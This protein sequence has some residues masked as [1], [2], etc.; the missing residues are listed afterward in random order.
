MPTDVMERYDYS[1]FWRQLCVA[2]AFFAGAGVALWAV[3]TSQLPVDTKIGLALGVIGVP[4][5]VTSTW[6]YVVSF[7]LFLSS[8]NSSIDAIHGRSRFLA[9]VLEVLSSFALGVGLWR[10]FDSGMTDATKIGVAT[11]CIGVPLKLIGY[12]VNTKLLV[13]SSHCCYLQPVPGAQLGPN[14]GSYAILGTIIWKLSTSTLSVTTKLSIG[15]AILGARQ[16]LRDRLARRYYI[17]HYDH[18]EEAYKCPG[19]PWWAL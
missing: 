4:A 18:I 17:C 8:R 12:Y 5:L 9:D 1:L 7:H 2:T 3:S 13:S 15:M 19:R 6:Q 11:G 14:L 10:L 16:T